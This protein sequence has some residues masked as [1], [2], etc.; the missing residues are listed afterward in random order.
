[1]DN[2]DLNWKEHATIWGVTLACSALY[3]GGG[4]ALIKY[5]DINEM[6]GAGIVVSLPILAGFAAAQYIKGA[7]IEK[8]S[9]ENDSPS[10]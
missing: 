6:V 1:M 4:Y 3:I 10:P 9:D 7:T 5:T 8:P 2:G